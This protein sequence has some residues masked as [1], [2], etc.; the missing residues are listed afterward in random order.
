MFYYW[1]TIN[2]IYNYDYSTRIDENHIDI[3]IYF[4]YLLYT[5]LSESVQLFA[6]V[7]N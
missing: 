4:V 3:D 2:L 7:S 5:N 6:A 1:F